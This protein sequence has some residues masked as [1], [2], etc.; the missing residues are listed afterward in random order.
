M[1]SL[2]VLIFNQKKQNLNFTKS[3]DY[4]FKVLRGENPLPWN[5]TAEW[6]GCVYCVGSWGRSEGYRYG[7]RKLFTW[8]YCFN[9]QPHNT[10][11]SNKTLKSFDKVYNNCITTRIWITVRSIIYNNISTIL[12]S[13]KKGGTDTLKYLISSFKV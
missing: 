12:Y 1:F 7:S 13:E 4:W 5:M 11:F 3:W 2:Y 10:H 8:I 6:G 9:S